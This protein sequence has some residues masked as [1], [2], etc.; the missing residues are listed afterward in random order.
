M[1]KKV[2]VGLIGYG[3]GGRMFHAPILTS[4]EGLKLVKVRETKAPN[5][6]HINSNYPDAEIVNDSTS[7]FEDKNIELVVITS[8]N[9]T[10]YS[11]A[12]EA[13]LAGKHVVVDKPFTVS[14]AEADELINLAQSRSLILSVYHNRRFDSEY[15]TVKKVLDSNTL[16]R[17]IEYEAHFDRYRN[18]IKPDTWKEEPEPGTGL[19]YDLGS[20]LIDQALSYF[21]LPDSVYADIRIQREGGQ[22]T[23]NFELVLNFGSLKATLKAGMLVKEIGPRITLLGTEGAYQSYGMD[24]QEEDLKA[25]IFPNDKADWGV[26]PESSWGILNTNLNGLNFKGKVETERGDYREYYDNIYKTILGE[27]TLLVKAEEARD[28][29]KVIEMAMKSNEE[30]RV[31]ILGFGD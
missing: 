21:G 12:K 2:N 8:P 1:D 22:I 16:G 14:S 7:I 10:H 9:N 31:V 3:M 17:L 23:D 26:A 25:G 15:K 20:H 27:E 30:K 5:I 24:V 28:T 11:L 6:A 4:I 19:L 29:I 18:F 13:L